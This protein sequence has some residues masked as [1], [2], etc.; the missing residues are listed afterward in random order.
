MLL[1]CGFGEDSWESLGLQGDPTSQSQRKSVLNI[2]WK[3]WCWNS[4]Y[5]GHLMWRTDSL[6]KTLMQWNIEGRRGRGRQRIRCLDGITNSMDMSFS[7]L[8]ELMMDREIWHTAVHGVTK[9]Q[10]WLS[11]WTD[12]KMVNCDLKAPENNFLQCLRL[13][14]W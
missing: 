5:F 8:W 12:I 1:D 13:D 14:F 4:Q 3:D 2:H 11:D 9:G 10:T 7:K 6:E